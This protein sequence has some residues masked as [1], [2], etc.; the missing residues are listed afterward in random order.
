MITSKNPFC[1]LEEIKRKIVEQPHRPMTEVRPDIDPELS[2]IVDRALAKGRG[3]LSGSRRDAAPS[4]PR[5]RDASKQR[6]HTRH[7]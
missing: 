4:A 1:I 7:R 3:S 5:S 6:N 2:A